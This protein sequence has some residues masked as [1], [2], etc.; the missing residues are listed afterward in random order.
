MLLEQTEEGRGQLL[1]EAGEQL[2]VMLGRP[3][4]SCSYM[5][6]SI[7]RPHPVQALLYPWSEGA[8]TRKSS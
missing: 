5:D 4:H 3:L 1:T 8:Y 2:D 6:H 7:D